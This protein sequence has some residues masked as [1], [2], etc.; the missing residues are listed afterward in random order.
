MRAIALA[1]GFILLAGAAEI[2]RKATDI[3]VTLTDGH[4]ITIAD[5]HGKVL[6]LA[7]ILTT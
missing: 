5:Y 4:K 3:D 1:M 2:P 6:C 7:F